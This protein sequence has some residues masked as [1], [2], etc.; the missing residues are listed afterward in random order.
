MIFRQSGGPL[1]TCQGYIYFLTMVDHFWCWPEAIPI[2][3]L[4]AETVAKAFCRTLG[5]NLWI[6][7][8]CHDGPRSSIRICPLS[9]SDKSF[10]HITNSYTGRSPC[11]QILKIGSPPPAR[12]AWKPAAIQDDIGFSATEMVHGS[13]LRLLGKFISPMYQPNP[14]EA[15]SYVRQPKKTMQSL[16]P[17]PARKSKKLPLHRDE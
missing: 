17:T 10:G 6:S 14:D 7:H 13:I 15:T 2:T 12:L 4:S 11:Y 5:S 3:D 16:G 1:P 8:N 9:I